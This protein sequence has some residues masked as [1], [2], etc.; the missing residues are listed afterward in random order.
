MVRL[1]DDLMEVS[2]ITRGKI[3]LRARAGRPGRRCIAE[4]G[5]D[6]PAADRGRGGHALDVALPRRA[7]AARRR[8]G[9]AGAGVR[10]PAQQRRQVHRAKAAASARPRSARARECVVA[11]R[12]SG[13]GIAAEMLPRVFD[14][15]TQAKRG[16]GRAQGGLGIGL[17][18][19]QEPGRDAR[20][21]RRGA[22]RRA[23]LRQRVHRAP[24]AGA[25]TPR[26]RRRRRRRAAAPADGSRRGRACW[27]STTTA[28][29]PTASAM[30]LELLGAE[31]CVIARRR[32]PRWRLPDASGPTSCCSTSACRAWTATRWRGGCATSREYDGVRL[33]ALTGWGQDGDRRRT[34]AERASTTT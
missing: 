32:R 21:Q 22:Q 14:M 26:P 18:L 1:V 28:T 7:A 10:Q 13:I 24:A 9:A 34:R 25:G 5:R 6:E 15:F 19:V 8:R 31:V 33:V 23:R 3:E 27:S 11:V 12:D 30:L 2:R 16:T 17:T 29:P 4:R 20:R